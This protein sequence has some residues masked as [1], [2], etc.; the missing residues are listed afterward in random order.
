[1][2]G[3]LQQPTHTITCYSFRV[4]LVSRHPPPFRMG[5]GFAMWSS[6]VPTQAFRSSIASVNTHGANTNT[7]RLVSMTKSLS[8]SI[9]KLAR[10]VGQ[11]AC[12]RATSSGGGVELPHHDKS[13]MVPVSAVAHCTCVWCSCGRCMFQGPLPTLWSLAGETAIGSSLGNG[14]HTQRG[15]PQSRG[16]DPMGSQRARTCLS[17]MGSSCTT[18]LVRK[19]DARRVMMVSM[20]TSRKGTANAGRCSAMGVKKGGFFKCV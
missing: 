10:G 14:Q 15:R 6:I 9:E 1:M 19:C 16:T 5:D 4:R 18:R 2:L 11:A 13:V 8:S 7:S 17:H 3:S 12:G 20:N